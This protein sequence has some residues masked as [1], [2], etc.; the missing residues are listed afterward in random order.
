MR[1]LYILEAR[2]H[3]K[4]NRIRKNEIIG[5][6]ADIKKLEDSKNSVMLRPHDYNSVSFSIKTE[7][8][9]FHA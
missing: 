9:P 4:I 5:V 7:I 1:Q 2:W 3:D 6:H 8:Q